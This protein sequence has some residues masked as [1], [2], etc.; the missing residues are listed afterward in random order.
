LWNRKKQTT[1]CGKT[2][3]KGFL[4]SQLLFIHIA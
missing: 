3:R 1:Q 2:P 4:P